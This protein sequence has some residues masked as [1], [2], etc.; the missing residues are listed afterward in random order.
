[1]MEDLTREKYLAHGI[2][3][4]SQ[5]RKPGLEKDM[6][7]PPVFDLE[8]RRGSGKLT[9]KVA[10]VTGGDSGIGKAAAIGFAKEGAHLAIV[11][12]DE[13]IDAETTKHLIEK[14]GV[15]CSLH[16]GDIADEAFCWKVIED[17]IEI[18]G[19]IDILVN[20]AAWAKRQ[21]S[22]LDISAEQLQK[23]FATNVFSMFYLTK[24]VLPH[25]QV[26]SSI[27]NTSSI[28]AYAGQT[29]QVDYSATKG[30]IVAF[31]RAMALELARDGV[32]VN[33]IA[34]GPIW[35]PLVASSHSEE[36]V[37][38]FGI[39]TPLGRPG[40]PVDLAGSFVLLASADSAYMTG[41]FLHINGGAYLSS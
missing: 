38:G 13:H 12:F 11:Y 2:P 31:T 9:D 3:P 33:G 5:S 39:S 35:T 15:R 7:P 19:K 34:P 25:L 14:Q 36:E 18:H 1:M 4:Q 30:A 29:G 16:A 20:N 28:D 32:R 24:A 17:V 21:D 27:I 40:Q 8:S 22:I 23:T 41:Q 10:V 37:A 26:G 6:D